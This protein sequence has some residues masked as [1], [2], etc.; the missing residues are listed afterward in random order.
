MSSTNQ[1]PTQELTL[2]SFRHGKTREMV[3]NLPG[4]IRMTGPSRGLYANSRQDV[5]MCVLVNSKAP[6]DYSRQRLGRL[7]RNTDISLRAH[8]KNAR[9]AI[10]ELLQRE[11]RAEQTKAHQE[12]LSWLAKNREKY[13]GQWIAVRGAELL[14][15]GT[16]AREVYTQVRGMK[17]SALILKIEREDLPFAGW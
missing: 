5:S 1:R 17:P 4:E 14:A 2:S 8:I 10:A 7:L 15:T 12:A 11:Q 16:N 6:A 9:A 13:A 3:E